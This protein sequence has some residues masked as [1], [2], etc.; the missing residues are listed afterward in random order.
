MTVPS[1]LETVSREI[2]QI[3]TNIQRTEQALAAA[4]EPADIAFVRQQLLD[5]TKEKLLLIKRQNMF[6]EGQVS[7]EHCLPRSLLQLHG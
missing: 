6:L 2:A 4:Q 7:G 1:Q 5:L 3:K